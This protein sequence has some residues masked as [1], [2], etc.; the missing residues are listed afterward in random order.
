[1]VFRR[2]LLRGLT[3]LP[4]GY[5]SAPSIAVIGRAK[6]K[7][8]SNMKTRQQVEDGAYAGGGEPSHG[9]PSAEAVCAASGGGKF[10][11]AVS[12]REL[13]SGV[14]EEKYDGCLRL[15]CCRVCGKNWSRR[16]SQSNSP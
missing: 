6:E 12:V 7:F 1:M 13:A 16:E 15:K 8:F 10:A 2:K 14:D 11:G 5:T 3:I 4:P 9:A